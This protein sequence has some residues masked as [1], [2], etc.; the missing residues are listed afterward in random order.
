MNAEHRIITPEQHW[1]NGRQAEAF[2]GLLDR[3][4]K[5]MQEYLKL[6]EEL[7]KLQKLNKKLAAAAPKPPTP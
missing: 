6:S 1:H 3:H 7:K 2:F 4:D 5:L